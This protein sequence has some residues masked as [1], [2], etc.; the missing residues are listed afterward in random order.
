MPALRKDL[1]VEQG[2]DFTWIL[3]DKDSS[4]S[5]IDNTGHTARMSVRRAVNAPLE[6]GLTTEGATSKI[7]LGGANGNITVTMTAL[8]TAALSA[9][10]VQPSSGLISTG[11][12]TVRENVQAVYRYDLERIDASGI[13][14]RVRQGRLVLRAEISE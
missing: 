2:S 14:T 3:V 5:V 4:G 9:K 8:D 12:K 10:S 7:T 11:P 1:Y 13:V 6:L